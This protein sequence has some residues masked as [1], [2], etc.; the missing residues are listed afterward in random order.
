[1]IT[2]TKDETMKFL[3]SILNLKEENI[4]N[5]NLSQLLQA[6]LS[7]FPLNEITFKRFGTQKELAYMN[8]RTICNF[9]DDTLKKFLIYISEKYQEQEN[10]AL[11]ADF[12]SCSSVSEITSFLSGE[13]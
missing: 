11:P 2:M 5:Y 9:S 8:T 1:M 10:E 4:E 6:T 12:Y 7:H 3:K 13:K